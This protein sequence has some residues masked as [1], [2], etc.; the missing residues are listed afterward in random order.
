MLLLDL[1]VLGILGERQV[2]LFS[3]VTPAA[4]S[5]DRDMLLQRPVAKFDKQDLAPA[6]LVDLGKLGFGVFHRHTPF[7]QQL[8]RRLEF[9]EVDTPV[10]PGVDLVEHDLQLEVP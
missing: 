6:V 3:L 7:F 5:F 9:I 4:V 2:L 1:R 8:Q 10:I